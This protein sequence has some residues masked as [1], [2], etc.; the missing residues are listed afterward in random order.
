LFDLKE[1]FKG[2]KN[3]KT[4]SSYPLH[5]TVNLGNPDNPKYVNLGKMISKKERKAYL[6]LF[7]KY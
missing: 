5:K 4:G 2:P 7:K 6:K 3:K 1:Q